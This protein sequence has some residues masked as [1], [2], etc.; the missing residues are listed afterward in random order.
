MLNEAIEAYVGNTKFATQVSAAISREIS[1]GLGGPTT[2]QLTVPRP[3][4]YAGLKAATSITDLSDQLSQLT[5]KEKAS[6]LLY[7]LKESADN[8]RLIEQLAL[9]TTSFEREH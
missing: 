2:N 6:S 5:E 9:V 8:S 3:N 7:A 1:S 4:C